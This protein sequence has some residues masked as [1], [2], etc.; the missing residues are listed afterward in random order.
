LERRGYSTRTKKR[1]G[2]RRSQGTVDVVSTEAARIDNVVP[3]PA[4]LTL[5]EA[6]SDCPEVSVL[7]LPPSK[8]RPAR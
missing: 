2:T 8:D 7:V 6:T 1:I 3:F 4:R 5:R